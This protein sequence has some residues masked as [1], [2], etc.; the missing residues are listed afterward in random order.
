MCEKKVLKKTSKSYK[1]VITGK[2]RNYISVNLIICNSSPNDV[3][4][5]ESCVRGACTHE[6]GKK[7]CQGSIIN[8]QGDGVK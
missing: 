2:W 3:G 4:K 6:R 7:I 8:C 1:M 5:N